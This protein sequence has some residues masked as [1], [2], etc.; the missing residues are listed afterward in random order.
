MDFS[1]L[2]AFTVTDIT[3]HL[4]WGT[5]ILKF[6]AS[7]A[8]TELKVPSKYHLGVVVIDFSEA[9]FSVEVLHV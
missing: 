5:E 4:K 2:F 7:R 1:T 3:R 6:F 9:E 8:L